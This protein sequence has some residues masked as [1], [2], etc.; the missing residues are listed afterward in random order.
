MSA[1]ICSKEQILRKR[2]AQR[3]DISSIPEAKMLIVELIQNAASHEWRD[4]K[5]ELEQPQ[6]MVDLWV[7]LFVDNL[8]CEPQCEAL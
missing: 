1:R 6:M 7:D 4:A 3:R 2:R 5:T 8:L